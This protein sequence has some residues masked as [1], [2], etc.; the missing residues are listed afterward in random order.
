MI[1]PNDVAL[2]FRRVAVAVDVA[3]MPLAN[4]ASKT[5]VR[6]PPHSSTLVPFV[7]AATERSFGPQL[8]GVLRSGGVAYRLHGSVQLAGALA[9]TMPFSRSGQLAL[10]AVGQDLLADAAVPGGT[11]CGTARGLVG[12]EEAIVPDALQ[13]TSDLGVVIWLEDLSHG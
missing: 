7:V 4:G 9:L 1:D 13:E 5:A 12:T 8:L 2:D 3:G 6:L 11:R 10:L